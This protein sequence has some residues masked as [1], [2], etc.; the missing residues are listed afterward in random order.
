MKY[1]KLCKSI[2]YGHSCSNRKCLRHLEGTEPITFKQ[3]EFIE[4]MLDK[5]GEGKDLRGMTMTQ[6]SKLIRE[7]QERMELGE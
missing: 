4:D 2:I 3:T 1:C 5:L 6:A 7:L